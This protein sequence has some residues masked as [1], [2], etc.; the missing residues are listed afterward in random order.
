MKIHVV[1]ENE[2][3][4][5]GYERV[6]I[7]DKGI[8]LEKFSDNECSFILAGECIDSIDIENI[9]ELLF[10]LRQKMRLGSTIVIG[11][12]DIRVFCRAVI[13]GSISSDHASQVFSNNKSCSDVNH[14]SEILQKLGLE[15]ITTNISGIHYE[16]EAS[17]Q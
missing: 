4:I 11:G 6:V 5:E 15:I 10:K 8:E 1:R 7:N 9:E 2:K 17:R 14:I 13:N 16:I 3:H 12:T